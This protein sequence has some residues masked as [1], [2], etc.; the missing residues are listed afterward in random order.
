MRTFRLDKVRADGWLEQLGEGSQGFSQLCEVVGDRFV[1]FSVIAGIRISALTVDPRNPDG[2]TVEFQ[3][4]ETGPAQRLQLGEFRQRLAQAMLSDDGLV[5]PA[6]KEGADSEAIQ[7]FIG[8]RYVLLAPLFGVRL[9]ELR[10]R[11]D[12]D[13]SIVAQVDGEEHEIPL[14]HFRQLVREAV[15]EETKR[16]RGE[17]PFAIDLNVVEQARAAAAAEDSDLVAELLGGWPGPL[18]LLLRT[19]EGQNLTPEVRTTLAEALGLLGTA[20]ARLGRFDWAQEVLRLAIQWGQEQLETSA[21]LFRRL[22]EAYVIQGRHGEAI[23]VLRRSL[24]L[25]ASRS[26]LL[27]V[28]AVSFLE[29]GR[30]IAALLCVEEARALGAD[31]DDVADVR[32]KARTE[33][34]DA[35]ERFRAR[36]PG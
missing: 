15:G 33:L 17:S 22:G 7:S 31:E 27:P 29:R 5:V 9:D 12:D 34:G 23:G 21:D 16:N 10:I 3:V 4:G 6:P 24:A 1:G 19:A 30:T 2:S 20:Y 32:A 35:W 25:G 18:S 13:A 11:D 28:L 14:G 36:V 8:F 26:E